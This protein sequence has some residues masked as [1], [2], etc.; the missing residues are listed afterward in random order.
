MRKQHL[1]HPTNEGGRKGP[2]VPSPLLRHCLPL[3]DVCM[4]LPGVEPGPVECH[5][6]SPVRL[7]V[8]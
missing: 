6:N 1:K 7:I 3:H 8:Q 5:V 4:Q 2:G